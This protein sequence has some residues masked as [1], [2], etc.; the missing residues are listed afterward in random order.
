MSDLREKLEAELRRF[1]EAVM[2]E[3]WEV[4]TAMRVTAPLFVDRIRD[5]LATPST[6]EG[7]D[8]YWSTCARCG[9]AWGEH[10]RRS[11]MACEVEIIEAGGSRFC[12]C[13][14]F[15]GRLRSHTDR[16]EACPHLMATGAEVV[17]LYRCDDCGEVQDGYVDPRVTDPL[18]S[19]PDAPHVVDLSG[20]PVQPE[21]ES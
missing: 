17:R 18:G 14:R 12:S 11:R 13:E 1:L 21:E 6:G 19:T 9:H 16:D 8:L 10:G 15:V 4:D 7:E 2:G 5:L 20:P 3:T